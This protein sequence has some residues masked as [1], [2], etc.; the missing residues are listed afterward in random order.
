MTHYS[1]Q[2]GDAV[3]SF[4]DQV[5]Q[6]GD[7]LLVITPRRLVGFSAKSLTIPGKQLSSKINKILKTDI[8]MG[9]VRLRD[10]FQSMRRISE[11]LTPQEVGESILPILEN[12]LQLR[13]NLATI[14]GSYQDKLIRYVRYFGSAKGENHLLFFLQRQF[15][16]IPDNR[17]LNALK[18]N[19][20]LTGFKATEAFLDENYRS[21][22]DFL[23]V[24]TRFQY[25]GLKFHFILVN[26]KKLKFRQ[27]IRF[28]DDLGNVYSRLS[29]LSKVTGG[30]QV[31]TANPSF[32]VTRLRNRLFK[33]DVQSEV[34]KE[35][36]GK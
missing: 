22:F 28:K 8:V 1:P 6:S 21:N 32:F 24:N 4:F 19:P 29:K 17:T 27:G 31:T 14:R 20:N 5:F 35:S 25:A 36:I 3:T 9:A 11:T 2:L 7:R 33:G 13:K 26:E 16:A 23:R 18:E 34:V 10:I 12:Y 15:R 30:L